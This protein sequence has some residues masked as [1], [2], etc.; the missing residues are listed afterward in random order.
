MAFQN[1]ISDTS[2]ARLY[3]NLARLLKESV[4]CLSDVLPTFSLC[5]SMT[6]RF[7]ARHI[8]SLSEISSKKKFLFWVKNAL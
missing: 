5:I 8:D 1:K 7:L 2:L 3:K 6:Y 4:R